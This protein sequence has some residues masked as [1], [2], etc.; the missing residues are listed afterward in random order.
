M[1]D[2]PIPRA[3]NWTTPTDEGG[4][5]GSLSSVEEPGFGK[6]IGG[7]QQPP[8]T[9]FLEEVHKAESER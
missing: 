3:A 6:S 2:R 5:K 7:R 1:P 9:A 8:R 4:D